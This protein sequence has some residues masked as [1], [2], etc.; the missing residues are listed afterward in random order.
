MLP[1][2]NGVRSRTVAAN[3]SRLEKNL[4]VIERRLSAS[5]GPRRVRETSW[6]DGPDRLRPPFAALRANRQKRAQEMDGYR[7]LMETPAL[8]SVGIRMK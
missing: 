3:S 2:S 5:P 1:L 8:R 7:S 4:R 6:H